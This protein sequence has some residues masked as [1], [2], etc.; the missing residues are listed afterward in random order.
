MDE[1]KLNE[2][3]KLFGQALK[4]S[5]IEKGTCTCTCDELRIAVSEQVIHKEASKLD[6]LSVEDPIPT[7]RDP[8]TGQ[9]ITPGYP[10]ICLSSGTFPGFKRCCDECDYFLECYPECQVDVSKNQKIQKTV[11]IL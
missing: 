1:K 8:G 7:E 3:K 9:L 5:L 10:K 6:D 2:S 11:D 4:Q